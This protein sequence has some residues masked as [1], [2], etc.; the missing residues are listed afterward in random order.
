MFSIEKIT[1]KIVELPELLSD[2][3]LTRYTFII[4]ID[5]AK[6]PREVIAKLTQ[7]C[8][9][10]ESVYGYIPKFAIEDMQFR[11]HIK[12]WIFCLDPQKI[13]D[14]QNTFIQALAHELYAEQREEGD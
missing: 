10:F 11:A 12:F 13:M 4:Q 1:R 7:V 5:L 3:Y 8:Q 14:K 9:E 2:Q 6:S